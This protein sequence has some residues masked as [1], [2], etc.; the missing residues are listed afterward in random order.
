[1]NQHS[2]DIKI[3][4]NSYKCDECESTWLQGDLGLG[5]GYLNSIVSEQFFILAYIC[6][7]L[8]WN[9]VAISIS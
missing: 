4:I 6:D 7:R 8:S 3:F 5:L 1:M 9:D 2:N